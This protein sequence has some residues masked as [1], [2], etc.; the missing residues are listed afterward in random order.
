MAADSRHNAYAEMLVE[1]CVAIA[2]QADCWCH[3]LEID[4]RDFATVKTNGDKRKWTHPEAKSL[5]AASMTI[6]RL[7]D[8]QRERDDEAQQ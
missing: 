8:R 5:H 1:M 7:S 2:A 6:A 3:I 4:E